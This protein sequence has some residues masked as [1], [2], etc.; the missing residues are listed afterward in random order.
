ME[1]GPT[2]AE[3]PGQ[4]EYPNRTPEP[5]QAAHQYAADVVVSDGSGD[6]PVAEA[7]S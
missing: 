7:R 1:V 3:C 2:T 5:I 4:S 6:L